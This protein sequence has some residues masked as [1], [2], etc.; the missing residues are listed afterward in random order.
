MNVVL[1]FDI[2]I[3]CNGWKRLDE[4]F[5]RSFERYVYGRSRYGDYALPKTL[6]ILVKHDLRAV[7]FVEP[8]FSARFGAQFLERIVRLIRD[9]GQD[10][11]LHLHPEWTDEIRPPLLA[12]VSRKRQHLIYYGLDEQIQLIGSAK[13]LLESAGSGPLVAFRAGSFAA[14][15]NTYE[16]LRRNGLKFDSSVN[17]CFKISAQDLRAEYDVRLPFDV[18]GVLTYPVSV[19]R[20]GFG[21]LRPA[22]VG[23]CSFEEMRDAI[24]S[25]RSLNWHD[26]VVVSH[27]FEL[28][29]EDSS[30]PDRIVVGRFERLCAFL[31]THRSE[32]P[33]AGFA[34]APEVPV[35]GSVSA[36]PQVSVTASVRRYAE[37]ALRRLH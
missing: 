26:F 22:Q 36:L 13:A 34:D 19:F 18:R 15:L 6:E 7:F 17:R 10:V 3:W 31:S 20:D 1:T 30:L 25:A 9:A 4:S 5:P 35:E 2:E 27:N 33:V 37:Q 24:W 16:A 28:L 21:R 8:L 14:N 11:Q 12:D 32:L 23:A 29:R